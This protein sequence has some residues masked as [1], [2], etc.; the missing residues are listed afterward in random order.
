[1]VHCALYIAICIH[2]VSVWQI[3]LFGTIA[4]LLVVSYQKQCLVHIWPYSKGQMVHTLKSKTLHCFRLSMQSR[5]FQLYCQLLP[6]ITRGVMGM[7]LPYFQYPYTK[8]HR[9]I[10]V[11]A[12]NFRILEVE[13]VCQSFYLLIYIIVVNWYAITN[14][15]KGLRC[16]SHECGRTIAG[17]SIVYASC[18]Y[19]S[20]MTLYQ[21]CGTWFGRC[22]LPYM[23]WIV[24]INTCSV[25]LYWM[26]LP[27]CVSLAEMQ[28]DS[29]S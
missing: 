29:W 23:A 24:F 10:I 12:M 21:M 25:Q 19:R 9:I 6:C 27:G 14:T 15:T 28:Q 7:V 4:G 22:S 18:S 20:H 17:C 11:Y 13:V 5:L 1:M 8:Q 2:S 3:L 16:G 26:L